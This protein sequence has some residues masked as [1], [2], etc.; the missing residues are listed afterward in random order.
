MKKDII[1]KLHSKFEELVHTEQDTGVEF[2]LARE[3]Q[4]ILGYAKW[5]NF[6]KV[7]ALAKSI[8]QLSS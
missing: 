2:W 1:V 4:E 3:L 7:D 8:N 5:E 6:S